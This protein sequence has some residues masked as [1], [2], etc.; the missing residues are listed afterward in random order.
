MK[1]IVTII[2]VVL[3]LGGAIYFA[4]SAFNTSTTSTKTAPASTILPFGTSFDFTALSNF[5]KTNRL[6]P[7]PKVT[8]AEIGNSNN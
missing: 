1:K 3:A 5:N 6:F 8:P 2:I 7:Y 4:Y